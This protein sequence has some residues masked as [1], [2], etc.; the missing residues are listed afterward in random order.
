MW[1]LLCGWPRVLGKEKYISF[2][3]AHDPTYAR[4]Q[5][6]NA[7]QTI[8]GIILNACHMTK[9]GIEIIQGTGFCCSYG[10]IQSTQKSVAKW[11]K[12]RI[13]ALNK[14]NRGGVSHRWTWN[15]R[16]GDG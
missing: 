5:Q 13:L 14:V 9:A 4:N 1:K 6:V 8:M 12:A 11:N 3:L 10:H 16:W 2:Q 15:E 7:F